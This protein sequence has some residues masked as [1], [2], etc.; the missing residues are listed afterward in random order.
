MFPRNRILLRKTSVVHQSKKVKKVYAEGMDVI[1]YSNEIEAFI[2]DLELDSRSKITRAIDLLKTYEYRLSM[3]H[4]RRIAPGLYELRV[5][6]ADE[7]RLFYT[8]VQKKAVLLLG[9]RKKTQKTPK[10]ILDLAQKRC[11][12]LTSI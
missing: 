7:L 6:G 9:Y 8:F 1:Y 5:R 4:S 12:S 11:S 2:A 3:P 10:S